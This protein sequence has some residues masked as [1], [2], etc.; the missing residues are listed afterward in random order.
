VTTLKVLYSAA[1]RKDLAGIHAWT[2]NQF[3]RQQADVYL[4]QFDQILARVA[5][6]P[7]LARDAGY[8]PGL[9]KVVSGSHVVYFR[10]TGAAIRV[11]RVLHGR[12]DPE[13]WL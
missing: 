4:D 13:R 2:V 7:S 11:I 10:R 5:A 8:W 3:G 6:F 9:L 12:M 1:A